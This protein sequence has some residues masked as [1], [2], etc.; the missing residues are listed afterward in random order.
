MPIYTKTGDGGQTSLLS[1]RRVDKDDLRV[2][3]YGDVDELN[4]LLGACRA[5]LADSAMAGLVARV[6]EELFS[7]GAQLAAAESA[8]HAAIPRVKAEWAVELEREIDAA[9]AELPALR[10]FILP[11]GSDGACWLHLARTVCRRAE[12][13]LVALARSEPVPPEALTYLNRLSDWLFTMARLA[14]HREGSPEPIWRKP[15]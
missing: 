7:L 1:G 11:G 2:S 9:D 6:Q 5:H 4:A 10:H 13:Q 8:G 3:T 12:R 15:T 14:N